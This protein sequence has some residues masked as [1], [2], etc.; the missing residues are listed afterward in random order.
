MDKHSYIKQKIHIHIFNKNVCKGR[1]M[2]E[3]FLHFLSTTPATIS[4]NGY[5]I[6]TIDNEQT[7]ELDML[8]KTDKIYVNYEPISEEKHYLP[9]SS[10]IN[11]TTYPDTTNEYIEIVPFPNNHYDIIMKPFYYYELRD[12]RVLY[13]AMVGKFFVSIIST[14][15]TSITIYSGNSIVYQNNIPLLQNAKVDIKNNIMTLK[16]IISNDEYYLLLL[17]TTNFET[18]F[19][20]IVHSID[21]EQ[22]QIMSVKKLHNLPHHAVVCKVEYNPYK[23]EIFNVYEKDTT[24]PPTSK[25]FIPLYFLDAL[26]IKD[27]TLCKSMLSPKLFSSPLS[28]FENYFGNI[29]EVY[30]NRHQVGT[31]INITIKSNGYKN[32]NFSIVDGKIDDIDEVNYI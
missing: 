26:K 18:I 15:H 10:K 19:S 2:R 22:N 30:F 14:N 6:G 8:T 9:Y 7:F 5:N 1:N 13:S 3:N 23:K 11:T 27:E 31:D 16:G 24:T 28:K 21:E 4:V 20:D 29:N 17:N 32:Y 25:Y 12:A